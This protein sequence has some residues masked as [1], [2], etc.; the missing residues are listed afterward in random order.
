MTKR[1][2]EPDVD[3]TEILLDYAGDEIDIE[4]AARRLRALGFTATA[5]HEKVM[6]WLDMKLMAS[7]Y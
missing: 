5:A 6:D 7:E 1:K 3:Y 2:P 4:E